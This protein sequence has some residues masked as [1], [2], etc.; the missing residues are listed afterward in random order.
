M[1]GSGVGSNVRKCYCQGNSG[2]RK[3][4]SSKTPHGLVTGRGYR[5]FLGPPPNPMLSFRF[6]AGLDL[7]K[8]SSF[9]FG[10]KKQPGFLLV[11]VLGRA[12]INPVFQ[13]VYLYGG[14]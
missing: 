7:A 13:M 4:A 12:S 6:L 14:S 11:L 5:F 3:V 9:G 2:G 10:T 1:G 8:G